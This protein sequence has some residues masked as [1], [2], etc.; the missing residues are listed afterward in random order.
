MDKYSE[1]NS[2]VK[3]EILLSLI[4]NNISDLVA[5]LDLKGRRLY[6]S[7][8]YKETL[9]DP[10]ILKGTDSFSE[11]H[12]EDRER[13]KKIFFETVQTGIGQRT[14][15]RFV[16]GD[17]SFR[18][19]ESQGDVI[20]DEKGK[21]KNVVVV[22]RDVTQRQE[23][24]NRM[25]LL[26][27]AL[28]STKDAFSLTDLDN[29]ILFVNPAHC[30]M[31]GY[32]EE[33]LIKKSIDILHSPQNDPQLFQQIVAATI[34]GKWSGELYNRR[35]DGTDF[36]IELWT[37]VLKNDD[38]EP[39]GLIR[40]ARDI[41]ERKQS[42]KLQ[43]ATYKFSDAAL[44]AEDLPMLFNFIHQIVRELMPAK[45]FYIALYDEQNEMLSF[46]Y[47]ADE[48][49]RQPQPKKLGR[50]LTEY[51]LRTGKPLLITPKVFNELVENREVE[52]IGAPSID[53]LGIPLKIKDKTIGVLVVQ[54]YTEGVRYSEKDKDVLVFVS[55]QVAIAIERKRSEEALRLSEARYRRTLDNML[56][57][58]QIIGFDW[59]YIYINDAAAEQGHMKREELLGKTMM[60]VYPGIENTEMFAVLRQCMEERDTRF[61]VN[62]F[63]YPD[64]TK[65]WFE[66]S[67]QPVPEGLFI[68]SV[69]ITER[70]R[71]EKE[72]RLLQTMTQAIVKATDFN[73]T[74]SVALQ[75]VCE[76]TGWI[77]GEAWIPRADDTILE[78][79]PV[80]YSSIEGLEIFR[81]TSSKFTFAPGVGLPGRVWLSKQSVWIQDVT[82]DANFLRA[83]IAKEVGLR[84]GVGIPILADDK[85]VAVVDFFLRESQIE[86]KRLIEIVTAVAAQLGFLFRWKRTEGSLHE[87]EARLK[88]AQRIA[89]IGSWEFDIQKNELKWSDEIYRMFDI[90]PRLFGA[91][92]EAFLNSIHPD[93]REF[94]NKAYTES[95]KTKTPYDIEHRLLMRGGI[96]KF[97]HERCETLYDEDGKPI[98]S[99]GTVQDITERKQTEEAKRESEISYHDLFNSVT[100]AIY[101]QDAEG[102]FLDVNDGAVKMYGYPREFFIGKTPA[103]LSAPGKNDMEAVNLAI[104]KAFAGEPQQLEFWGLRSSGEIFPKDVRL[105]KGTYFGKDV[106]IAM[107]QDITERKKSEEKILEQAGLMDIVPNAIFIQDLEHQILTWSQG[108]ERMYGWSQQEAIGKTTTTLFYKPEYLKSFN[109]A[110]GILF[111]R[112]VWT[113]ELRHLTEEGKEIF[114]DCYWKLMYDSDGKPKS[115][116]CVNTD[117]TE[118]KLLEGQYLRSQR[119]ESIGTLAGGIAH[120]LNNVLAPILLSVEVLKKKF[121]DESSQR[122]L[123]SLYTVAQRGAGIVKQI[124][125]FA[126]GAEGEFSLIQPR[127]IISDMVKVIQ[128]TFPKTITI[129]TDIPNNIWTIS[130]DPTQLHQVILN[131]CV[132]A[133]DAM[134]NGGTITIEA[135]NIHIDSS[136]A[137]MHIDAKVGPHVII[138]VTDTG[139]GIPQNIIDRIFE[140]FFTTKGIGKGTGLGLSTVLS[141]VKGHNGFINVY[142]EKG[143]G[144]NFR[145]YFPALIEAKEFEVKEIEHKLPLG[146]NETILVIDD[147]ECVRQITRET[148]EAHGY[149]VL[150]ACDGIDGIAIYA[151]HKEDIA[152]TLTD[153]VMPFMDGPS[154]I[155]AL[156]KMNPDIK[157]IASSGLMES[158]QAQN[159][160]D[161]DVQGF[162]VKPYTAGKLLVIISELLK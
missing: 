140:P 37:S 1:D 50:G 34:K 55:N 161:G 51:V 69:D 156:R 97:V 12:P 31:Y 150:T 6:N 158:G 42:E 117:V 96:I 71:S 118:K 91:S 63:K 65:G 62:E 33:E 3:N 45:N 131:L 44:T 16:R 28:S 60:E 13:I 82:T 142:S 121:T 160:Q 106:L 109:E 73:T 98:R 49:D 152:L 148:L 102:R 39:V 146:N 116:L 17:G 132:N 145:V 134:P 77:C 30:E 126:R 122:I 135:S 80:W 123:E 115:V 105:Y 120:D 141:I 23:L 90:D 5:V 149:T 18:Y 157:I 67:I 25:R 159:I 29:K 11:I 133:R 10:E 22:S 79:A 9:D 66:L 64:G 85:V 95:L 94:V 4:L 110:M 103:P 20:K 7:P 99:I 81:E 138:T 107:A 32:T 84:A 111:A 83:N 162:L 76:T 52:S 130:G 125:T 92:Y 108:A 112:G 26:A 119:M 68:L 38:R 58:C 87:S 57:G 53:W 114:I 144:T 86:D 70:K 21:V 61:M 143:K 104:K 43:A 2:M 147:E 78:C 128:E 129:K 88:E 100:E 59:C 35:K 153:M 113:G 14:E 72:N 155:R 8:S 75:Q 15:Y 48:Y 139:I 151:E 127:H 41:T 136:Y 93:D 56:E 36:P 137:Q 46:P 101:I 40:V 24:E 27:S 74:M 124:L 54:S 89:H 19:I 47:F 154:T